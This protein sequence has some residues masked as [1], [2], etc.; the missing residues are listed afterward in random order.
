MKKL[1][2]TFLLLGMLLGSF[3]MAKMTVTEGGGGGAIEGVPG[4]A[5]NSPTAAGGC[6]PGWAGWCGGND[7]DYP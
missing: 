7:L 2:V 6:Y 5:S 3:A 4:W 1:L